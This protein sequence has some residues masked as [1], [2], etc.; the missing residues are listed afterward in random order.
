[1]LTPNF[2]KL[3]Q[4]FILAATL[5]FAAPL[6]NTT[7]PLTAY[8]ESAIIGFSPEA[9]DGRHQAALG[10]WNFGELLRQ[11]KPLDKRLNLYV[12]AP[13]AQYRSATHPEYDHSLVV[14]TLTHDK[15]REWDLYWCFIL[16]WRLT[17]DLRSEKELLG[18]AQQSFRLPDLFDVEDIP[19]HE[20]FIEKTGVRTLED[21]RRYRR[22][23]GTLPRVLI[24]PAHQAVS[25]T[26]ERP[27]EEKP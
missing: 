17:S 4:L 27:E 22:K 16:D 14:N 18:A 15:S 12:V 20:L 6:Q 24:L 10:P 7:K 8:Y 11:E 21:L 13:G 25:A 26:A 23:D 1:V 2:Q 9:P 5:S 3:F 19:A